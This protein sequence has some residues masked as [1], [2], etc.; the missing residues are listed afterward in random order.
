MLFYGNLGLAA[1]LL[2]EITYSEN[3]LKIPGGNKVMIG[4]LTIGDSR[5]RDYL[6]S[7]PLLYI[8][9]YFHFFFS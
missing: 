3:A 2:T 4:S 6:K 1:L 8:L 5:F 7:S 9:L